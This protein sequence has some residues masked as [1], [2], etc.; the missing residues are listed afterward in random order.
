MQVVTLEEIILQTII[1]NIYRVHT[2]FSV[3]LYFQLPFN[4]QV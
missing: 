2:Y 1:Y 3:I 4:F